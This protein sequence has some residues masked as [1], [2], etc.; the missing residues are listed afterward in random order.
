[1]I[2]V[3]IYKKLQVYKGRKMVVKLYKLGI[4]QFREIKKPYIYIYLNS[5][6]DFKNS[7]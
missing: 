1:M 2:L 6:L 3:H 4:L 5:T 7:P